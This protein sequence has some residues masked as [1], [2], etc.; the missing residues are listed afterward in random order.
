MTP[1]DVG[2][3][4]TLARPVGVSGF[5]VHTYTSP[6]GPDFPVSNTVG[7]DCPRPY[8]VPAWSPPGVSVTRGARCLSKGV[9][10]GGW[11]TDSSPRNRSVWLTPAR[12]FERSIRTDVSDL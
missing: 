3:G 8:P 1:R 11:S 5:K 10:P 4:G 7:H 12:F 9:C 6:V 2:E